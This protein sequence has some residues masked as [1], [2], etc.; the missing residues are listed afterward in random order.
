M[1]ALRH[2]EGIMPSRLANPTTHVPRTELFS[3]LAPAGGPDFFEEP[4]PDDAGED[5]GNDGGKGQ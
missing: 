4:Y 1:L 5:A 2:R 3:G